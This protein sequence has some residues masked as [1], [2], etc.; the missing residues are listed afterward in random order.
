MMSGNNF[1][2]FPSLCLDTRV[3]EVVTLEEGTCELEAGS[4]SISG[5]FY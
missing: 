1:F 3:L 4:Q 2:S 5:Y